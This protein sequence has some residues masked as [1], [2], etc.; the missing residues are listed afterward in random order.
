MNSIEFAK[1]HYFYLLIL[2]VPIVIYYIYNQKKYRAFLLFSKIPEEIKNIK[3][4]KNFLIHIPFVLKILAIIF[5]IIALAR[6]QSTTKFETTHTEGIDIIIALDISGSMLA[7]DF[8]PDRL[9]ASKEIAIEFISGRPNDRIGLVLFSSESFTQCPLTTDKAVLINLFKEV[10]VGMIEDGTAIGM[11]IANAVAR[12]KNSN[13]KSKVI[14]LLTDGVNNTGNI[15]PLTA[16]ELARSFGIRVYTIGIGT[17]GVAPYPFK[18]IFGRTFLQNVP[19]EIDENLLKK[20]AE[21]TDGRY[22]RATNNQKLREIYAEIDKMEKSIINKNEYTRKKE[23][24]LPFAIIAFVLI[25]LLAIFNYI[26]IKK[27]P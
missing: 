1:P 19:V 22:F 4:Y 11:G 16:A 10:K 18:D 17:S 13:A 21:I 5:L 14:I 9:E 3:S 6:P 2:V 23:E 15:D 20:I 12:L 24:Y 27:L 8:K 7:R 26:I 25:T